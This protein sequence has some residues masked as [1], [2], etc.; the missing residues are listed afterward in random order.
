MFL[1][2]SIYKKYTGKAFIVFNKSFYI[3]FWVIIVEIIGMYGFSLIFLSNRNT[4]FYS[5]FSLWKK[6]GKSYY[7]RLYLKY[8]W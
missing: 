6:K 4:D 3:K 8:N 7:Y 2:I 1:Y 5:A